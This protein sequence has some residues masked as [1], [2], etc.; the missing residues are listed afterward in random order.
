MC[1]TSLQTCN[2]QTNQT[3]GHICL[4]HKRKGGG[5]A[6]RRRERGQ[7]LEEIPSA[8]PSAL[9]SATANFSHFKDKDFPSSNHRKR[10]HCYYQASSLCFVNEMHTRENPKSA[11]K[12]NHR[13]GEMWLQSAFHYRAA[14]R[15]YFMALMPQTR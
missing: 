9:C 2:R 14:L 12:T 13:G 15:A 7:E 3:K 11:S 4:L 1:L 5:T 10:C 6:A 8:L